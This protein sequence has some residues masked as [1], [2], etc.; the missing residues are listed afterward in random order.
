MSSNYP[1]AKIRA[2]LQAWLVAESS[3]LPVI[4]QHQNK[5]SPAGPFISVYIGTTITHTGGMKDHREYRS[6]GLYLIHQHRE[7]VISIQCHGDDAI[8][9]LNACKDAMSSDAKYKTYFGDRDLSCR[10]G[11]VNDLTAIK[12]AQ[13]EQRAQMDC[14]IGSTHVLEESTLTVAGATVTLDVT[15]DEET[16]EISDNSEEE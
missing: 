4:W 12:G 2:A 9:V 5:P 16:I 1:I 11:P 14:F 7:T 13:F 3:G 15:I 8:Y 10:C 6:P